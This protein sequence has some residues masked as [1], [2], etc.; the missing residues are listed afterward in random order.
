[1]ISA[2]EKLFVL[3]YRND[4]FGRFGFRGGGEDGA[5]PEDMDGLRKVPQVPP[6]RRGR[7]DRPYAAI[8]E[9]RREVWTWIP[10]SG[11]IA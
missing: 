1:M 9:K 2:L 11:P 8:A 6:L 10:S 7:N 4:F 3:T 5:A